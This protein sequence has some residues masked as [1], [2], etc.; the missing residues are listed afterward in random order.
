MTDEARRNEIQR[1]ADRHQ[2]VCRQQ[3]NL[4]REI[5]AASYQ[6]TPELQA[7]L[8]AS[9]AAEKKA[10]DEYNVARQG[11]HGTITVKPIQ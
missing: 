6:M 11:W 2:K 8:E 4:G 1:M 7:R 10:R 3:I 9:I 5:E